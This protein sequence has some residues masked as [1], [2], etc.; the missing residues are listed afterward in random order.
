MLRW[1][2]DDAEVLGRAI[3]ESAEHVRPWMA[4]I[5][6]EPVALDR[7]RAIINEWTERGPRAGTDSWASF[8]MRG[9]SAAV[10]FTT[11]WDRGVELGYWIHPSFLRRGL[12]TEV[13]R[14]LT[15]AALVVPGITHVGIHHDTANV[16]S[17]GIPRKLGFELVD[18]QPD[19]P[20]APAELGIELRWRMDRQRWADNLADSPSG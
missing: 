7:R 16:R 20:E 18:E 3:R 8:S 13:A 14:L 19:E 12:A 4:W 9:S 6:Q 1:K 17:A 2:V 10:G 11:R 15:D 5:A